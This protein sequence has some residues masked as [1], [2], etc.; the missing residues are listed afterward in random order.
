MWLK[1]DRDAV[2]LAVPSN[3]ITHLDK[4]VPVHHSL[5]LFAAGG[6]L[7]GAAFGLLLDTF[8]KTLSSHSGDWRGY[9]T[10]FVVGG[11]VLGLMSGVIAGTVENARWEAASLAAPAQQ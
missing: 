9:R 6:V 11:G 8:Y 1:S 5:L 4:W 3:A 10:R 2:R 7:S